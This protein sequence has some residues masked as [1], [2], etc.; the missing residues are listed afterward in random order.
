MYKEKETTLLKKKIVYDSPYIP[1]EWIS[2]HG[3]EPIRGAGCRAEIDMPVHLE[4]G[5]CPYMKEFVNSAAND[6]EVGAMVLTTTCDQMRRGADFV[7]MRSNTP[8]FLMNIPSSWQTA[9]I[10]KLYAGELDRLGKFFVSLG[11]EKV[12]AESIMPQPEKGEQQGLLAK[13]TVKA[14]K[15]KIPIALLGGHFSENDFEIIDLIE[16]MGG[17]VTIDGTDK[18]ERGLPAFTDKRDSRQSVTQD[19]AERYL[20]AIPDVFQRPNNRLFEWIKENTWDSEIRGMILIR[21]LWCDNWHA[22]VQRF[23]EMSK[24]PF[25]DIELDGGK[26]GHKVKT[27]IQAFMEIL[28]D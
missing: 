19:L 24:V 17:V 14:E 4:S 22:E 15:G 13:K 16:G 2:A 20:G 12:R 1:A 11:G 25:L 28:N 10:Y 23:R 26:I 21:Y 18:G 9:E 27:K 3:F 7:K 6:P 5:V 8:C